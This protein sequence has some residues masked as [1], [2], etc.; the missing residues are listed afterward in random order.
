MLIDGHFE[1]SVLVSVTENRAH[2]KE[3]IEGGRCMFPFSL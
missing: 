2:G 1:G 3:I